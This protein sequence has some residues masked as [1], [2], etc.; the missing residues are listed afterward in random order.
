M[1]QIINDVFGLFWR[2][3]PNL[4]VAPAIFDQLVQDLHD[5]ISNVEFLTNM[6][7]QTQVGTYRSSLGT[8]DRVVIVAHSQGNLFAN[9]AFGVLT[10]GADGLAAVPGTRLPIIAVATP[11]LFVAGRSL[12]GLGHTTLYG[13]GIL[14]VPTALRANTDI[15]G[16][17]C[18]PLPGREQ[19][20]G[21]NPWTCH[22]FLD[23]YLAGVISRRRIINQTI[24][25][26]IRPN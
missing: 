10:T 13:D 16:T 22:S 19:E 11:Q 6:D 21:L 7:L 5:A 25:S 12:F 15:D 17:P 8:S 4:T 18:M 14:G 9:E 1:A 26:M 2:W 23:S 20:P 3:L 24:I